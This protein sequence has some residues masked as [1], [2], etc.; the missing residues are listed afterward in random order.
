MTNNMKKGK[1]TKPKSFQN[2]DDDIF[3]SS[4]LSFV[5][6]FFDD[7]RLKTSPGEQDDYFLELFLWVRE[8]RSKDVNYHT[9]YTTWGVFFTFCYFVYYFVGEGRPMIGNLMS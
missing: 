4:L 2:C 1:T 9:T 8:G 3:Y 7:A 6:Y 5:Y